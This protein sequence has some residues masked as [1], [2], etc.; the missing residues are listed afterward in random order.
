LTSFTIPNSV[1]SI[2]YGA[3]EKCSNLTSITIPNSV[4]SIGY[5]A[6]K[7]CSNLTSITIHKKSPD[8]DLFSC[9]ATYTDRKCTLYV[10]R[11][12]IFAYR[13]SRWRE[14]VH[15][16][17]ILGKDEL[18]SLNS[19]IISN[20]QVI[21][22]NPYR[23]SGILVGAT[24]KEKERQ[25][26]RLKQYLEAEQ[27]PPQDDFSFPILG[28]MNRTLESI[29]D[30]TAKLNL[31]SDKMN[32]ALFWFYKGNDITDEAAFEALK[33]G[34]TN[35]ALQIWEQLIIGTEEYGDKY[36]KEITKKN[37]SAFHNWFILE[38]LNK[39]NWSLIANLKF[40]ES[41]YCYELKKQATDET[42]KITKGDLQLNFLNIVLNEI[43]KGNIKLSLDELTYMVTQV[44]FSAKQDFLKIVA[45]KYTANITA[46]IEIARKQRTVNKV[47][48][49]KT[50]SI[51]YVQTKDDLEQLKSICGV[52]S[53]NYSSVSD[54]L[55]NAILQCSID[56]SN[57]Y[58]DLNIYPGTKIMDLA[59]KA[60]SLAVGNIVK[61]RCEETIEVIQQQHL[62]ADIKYIVE[63]IQLFQ[64]LSASVKNAN[65]LIVS[66]KPKLD[67]IKNALGSKND[68]YMKFS[69]AIVGNAYGMLNSVYNQTIQA[70]ATVNPY[71]KYDYYHYSSK[72]DELKDVLQKVKDTMHSVSL[73]DMDRNWRFKLMLL[74][75]SLD[76]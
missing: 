73:L 39:T 36:W 17:E 58:K 64:N 5:D 70:L 34:D 28:V 4:L 48:A 16:V 40:L 27:E 1:I 3:F 50:G 12:T 76:T 10:P 32:A 24:A 21:F 47:D 60:Q 2:G 75:I 29:T 38:F 68:I 46:Q 45:Q 19:H 7:E 42:F 49:A 30:A 13:A 69:N 62:E 74:K 56:Y 59:R 23:T 14:F 67:T 71:Q 52:E 61:Q 51:L 15:I 33:D 37:H 66:C 31:D 57:H 8:N 20:I 6:F 9:F 72:L 55:A 41:D 35:K 53:L 22:N 18:F 25:I 44:D 26:R 65:D 54:K 43:D 11:G 63:K